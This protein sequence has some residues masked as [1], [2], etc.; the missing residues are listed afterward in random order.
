MK[1][2]KLHLV[3]FFVSLLGLS[4][5]C[6]CED[7][8]PSIDTTPVSNKQLLGGWEISDTES[9][10][11]VNWKYE[12]QVAA[13][14]LIFKMDDA[15]EEKA[16]G[17]IYFKNMIAYFINDGRVKDSSYYY[18]TDYIIHY[19]NAYLV[20]FYAPYMYVKFDDN[21]QLILYLRR[22]ETLE[23]LEKDGTF[24]DWMGTIR[25]VVD[26]AQCEIKLIRNYMPLYTELENL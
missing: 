26:D 19:T 12:P 13:N 7:E 20:G 18:I 16:E 11:D 9:Y 10:I 4:I 17:S 23:L 14:Y 2:R 5:L 24:D 25:D 1:I 3:S 8:V 15:F 22:K 21:G 6:S